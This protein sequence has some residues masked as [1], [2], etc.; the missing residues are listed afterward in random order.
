M[1]K[2]IVTAKKSYVS[3]DFAFATMEEACVFISSLLSN[4]RPDEDREIVVQ[5]SVEDEEEK[6]D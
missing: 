5:I 1:K 2:Y 4:Y 6:E 3:M